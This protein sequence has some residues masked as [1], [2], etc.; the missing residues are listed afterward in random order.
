M[1]DPESNDTS[2]ILNTAATGPL[3]IF[4]RHCK[5]QHE[6]LSLRELHKLCACLLSIASVCG[7]VICFQREPVGD[8]VNM[9]WLSIWV[10]CVTSLMYIL[11]FA[12]IHMGGWG[13]SDGRFW[14][15]VKIMYVRGFNTMRTV[16]RFFSVSLAFALLCL[17]VGIPSSTPFVCML[18]VVSEWQAGVAENQNQYDIKFQDKFIDE[19]NRL[20]VEN[21]HNYQISHTNENVTWSAFVIAR[22]IKVLTLTSMFVLTQP[23]DGLIFSAPVTVTILMWSFVVPSILDF[24]YFKHFMTFCQ[25]EIYRMISDCILL[26]LIIMFSLV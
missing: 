18:V 22:I 24:A 7:I 8:W 17:L 25:L 21:L 2:P 12:N 11:D 26:P 1:E 9:R 13:A 19:E 20:S 4:G 23:V 3:F 5:L 10:T 14:C 6:T 15:D 16:C